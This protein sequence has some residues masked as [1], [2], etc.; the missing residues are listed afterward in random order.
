MSRVLNEFLRAHTD[1]VDLK[2]NF[3]QTEAALRGLRNEEFQLAA[4]EHR[5]EQS[6]TGLSCYPLPDDQ[7]LLAGKPGLLNIPE[8][9]SV[10]LDKLTH[11][12]LFAR[13]DGCSSKEML[14]QNLLKVGLDFGSFESVIIS[15]DMQFTIQ[16]LV[17][18]DGVAF[19][20]RALVDE[21][22]VAKRLTGFQ[23]NGFKCS[24]GRSVVILPGKEQD[25][26]VLSLIEWIFKIV[27]P[28]RQP[29]MITGGL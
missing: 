23:V 8:D 7:M 6:F 3:V 14:R 10:E 26:L 11:L 2:F 20:S 27:A 9:G 4:I 22:L 19:I 24:R 29:Q 1:I 17:N 28:G 5:P 18:G 15:D 21:Y 13:R 16:S 25:P 12:R